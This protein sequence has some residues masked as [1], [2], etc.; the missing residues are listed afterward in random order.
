MS[1]RR[2][3]E[4]DGTISIPVEYCAKL[5]L[6]PGSTVVVAV[7]N[8]TVVVRSA[9]DRGD[10]ADR[11]SGCI[12]RETRDPDAPALEPEDCKADWTSDLP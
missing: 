8:E 10:A 6:E 5:G 11:L 9:V 1:E 2:R 4:E 3:I 12:G 7:E